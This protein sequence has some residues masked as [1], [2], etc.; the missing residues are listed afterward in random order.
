ML[1]DAAFQNPVQIVTELASSEA[2][3]RIAALWETVEHICEEHG[4]AV[5][6]APE[7]ILIHKVPIGA[8]PCALVE[9]PA[10]ARKT[11]AFFVALV[12]RIDL[13]NPDAGFDIEPLRYLTLEFS[14]TNSIDEVR[15][16]IGE[17]HRDGTHHSL[18][19]G[20]EPDIAAFAASIAKILTSRKLG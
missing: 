16:V 18:G 19:S 5:T 4:E 2:Q 14:A 12:L 9:M 1:R 13:I 8:C 17:W 20:P 15:T 11:E 6:L 10:A 3:T 7:D